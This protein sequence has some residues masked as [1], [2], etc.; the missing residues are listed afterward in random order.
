[1]DVDVDLN[2]GA[3]LTCIYEDQCNFHVDPRFGENEGT[4]T[5]A[6]DE[7]VFSTF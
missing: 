5:E 4:K 7:I 6:I 2:Y 3:F 1:M